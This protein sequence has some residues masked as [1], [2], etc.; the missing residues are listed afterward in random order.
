MKVGILADTHGNI[1][2]TAGAVSVF[3]KAGVEAVFH[4]G[5][6]GSYDVLTALAKLH[7][8]VHVVLGNVDVFAGDWEYRPGNA[9]IHLHGRFGDI[10]LG[11][12]RFALLHSDDQRAVD[13]AVDS[14]D[15]DFVLTGHSHEFHDFMQ[16]RTRCLNPGTAG[17]G[18]PSTCVVLDLESGGLKLFKL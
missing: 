16:G 11:G 12:C 2:A 9:G 7:V 1:P 10:Q 3:E 13:Q 17:R 5:D 14:G 4:C 15:F 8:P 6:I 18:M